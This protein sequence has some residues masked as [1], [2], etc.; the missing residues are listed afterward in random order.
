MSYIVD[1]TSSTQSYNVS[2]NVETDKYIVDVKVGDSVE[3]KFWAEQA[4]DYA[5]Q[6]LV[7]SLEAGSFASNALNSANSAAS[8][9]LSASQSA[10]TATTKANEASASASDALAS[11]NSASASA[12]TST[13]Q[14]GIATTQA[15]IATTQAGIATTQANNA[16]SSA[17]DAAASAATITN[18]VSFTGA[19]AF[20][21]LQRDGVSFKAVRENVP[22]QRKQSRELSYD[23]L[24]AN[25]IYA[26]DSFNRPNTTDA[27][28]LGTLPSGQNWTMLVRTPTSP[29]RIESKY[30]VLFGFNSALIAKQGGLSQ[31]II[32]SGA[33]ELGNNRS[34]IAVLHQD[35]NNEI[36]F[37]YNT[38]QFWI[39]K[40][41]GGI[42]SVLASQSSIPD[43]R[44]Q[45]SPKIT[46][47]VYS[48]GSTFCFLRMFIE[49]FS[50]I[51]N[52][53]LASDPD[54][55]SIV[56]NAQFVGISGDN[57]TLGI[58]YFQVKN[59]TGN[60]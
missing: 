30:A 8:S 56:N 2:V 55:L 49:G 10:T 32:F 12:S 35:S 6:A 15:G 53:S 7:S 39:Q 24:D 14:A 26:W 51:I 36:L 28:G 44:N 57:V 21:F 42:L 59:L 47:Q 4:Q 1:V 5:D 19:Q 17:N 34:I 13:T 48:N 3:S 60:I 46:C 29:R 38:F 41:V 11:Q 31:E 40:R 45:N 16:L 50:G 25:N 37:R 23:Y 33:T 20:D 22:L 52:L 9:E 54:V 58:N 43:I 27:Q 18:Q